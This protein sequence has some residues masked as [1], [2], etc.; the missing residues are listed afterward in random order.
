MQRIMTAAFEQGLFQHAEVGQRVNAQR[1]DA[2][3][4][5]VGVKEMVECPQFYEVWQ[6]EQAEWPATSTPVTHISRPPAH[7]SEY[8]VCTLL[9]LCAS[10][11]LTIPL[12]NIC[13]C[14]RS[15][16]DRLSTLWP[17]SRD[18][19]SVSIPC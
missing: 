1:R 15:E 5:Q 7:W 6:H 2:R 13:Q 18:P 9:D 17:P 11:F 3:V 14:L 8:T 4:V 16:R 19:I 12:A 10:S